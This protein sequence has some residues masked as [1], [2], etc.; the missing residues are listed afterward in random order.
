M[1]FY[2]LLKLIQKIWLSYTL[3]HILYYISSW[4]ITVWKFLIPKDRHWLPWC[5]GIL[6][7]EVI[8]ISKL[9]VLWG[10]ESRNGWEVTTFCKSLGNTICFYMMMFIN[11]F[12]H[13]HLERVFENFIYFSFRR[14]I[15]WISAYSLSFNSLPL[16]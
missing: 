4:I 11:H 7:S 10:R 14:R 15:F 8:N 9:I 16:Q 2:L 3:T 13:D 5:D 1:P 6:F 12:L